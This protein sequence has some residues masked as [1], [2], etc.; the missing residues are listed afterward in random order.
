MALMV[1]IAVL[2]ESSLQ[3]DARVLRH[4]EAMRRAGHDVLLIG[5]GPAPAGPI[6]V[7][8]HLVA[9][10]RSPWRTRLGL[11][12]RQSP[13]TLV[14]G[15]AHPLYWLSWRR[16]RM[17]WIL[18]AYRPEIVL[19]NDWPTLPLAV[20]AKR[21][22]GSAV[23]YDSHEF[24]TEEFAGKARWRLV[25][26]AHVSAIER[27]GIAAADAV[28]TVS[29]TLAERLAA[30][31]SLPTLPLVVHNR[32]ALG[33]AEPKATGQT[34]TV[35]YLG[36]ISPDRCLDI[37]IDSVALWHPSMRLVIQGPD[38]NGYRSKLAAMVRAADAHR[39]VFADPVSP[40]TVVE[41]ASRC[42][43]G[44]FL[45]PR[46]GQASMMLP[47]KIF[48]YIAAG[49]AIVAVDLPEI[50]SV[51]ETSGGGVL[52]GAVTPEVIA[53]VL[54]GLSIENIDTMKRANLRAWHG[55]D[56]A[57]LVQLLSLV[58]DLARKCGA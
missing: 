43:I 52:V 17:L 32:P 44:V 21:R 31:Y 56:G 55:Q 4:A 33:V 49:L 48:E 18:R 12:L 45:V 26:Q 54:N 29:R 11:L 51:L 35:L 20:A 16:L 22:L 10:A 1:R 27:Q 57:D 15:M 30:R 47:N 42:D 9:R 53:A 13:A 24:A 3:F 39:I 8:L 38:A 28:M 7:R 46:E 19:A 40:Q 50:R 34:V 23:I 5:A 41:V 2:S 58:D 37:L 25:S 36:L 14:S 6:A